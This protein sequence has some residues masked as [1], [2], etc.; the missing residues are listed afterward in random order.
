MGKVLAFKQE[1]TRP[2]AEGLVSKFAEVRGIRNPDDAYTYVQAQPRP[3]I[4][5]VDMRMPD[6]AANEVI[7]KLRH[8]PSFSSLV[9]MLVDFQESPARLNRQLSA[10]SKLTLTSEF[11]SLDIRKI[12][13]LFQISQE[14]FARMLNVSSRTAHRWLRGGE[15]RPKPELERL[16]RVV[17]GL[18]DTLPTEQAIRDYLHHPNPN[19]GT[20]TPLN[21][22][23]R[24]EFEKVLG[25]LQAIREGVYF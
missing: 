2:P 24:G 7:E 8:L 15:P 6:V 12:A 5:L 16:S 4:I 19:L 17:R 14:S 1:G 25:D 18:I 3:D 10:L 21:V 23:A 13:G 20:E 9:I 22:L 11:R